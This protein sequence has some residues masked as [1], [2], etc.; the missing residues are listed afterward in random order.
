ML[1]FGLPN[2]AINPSRPAVKHDSRKTLV[3][4]YYPISMK[5]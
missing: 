5:A 4:N 3:S 1:P 2:L